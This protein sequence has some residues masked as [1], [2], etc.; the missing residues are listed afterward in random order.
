MAGRTSA[1]DPSAS[2][3][4]R[5]AVLGG[6]TKVAAA[7]A[8]LTAAGMAVAPE[9]AAAG[10][11]GPIGVAPKG[12][13][14]IEFLARIDQD[15]DGLIAYGYLTS[16]AGLDSSALFTGAPGETTARLTAFAS[17]RLTT[18]TIVGEVHNLDVVGEMSIF[19][20]PN[21][22]ASFGNPSSFRSGTKVARY[23]LNLQDV[24][25]VIAPDTGIPT[26][27]GDLR[28]TE[29]AALGPGRPRFGQ[30]GAGLRLQAT[31]LGNRSEP[32]APRAALRVA[33]NLASV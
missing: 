17:G 20:L 8:A 33:G 28:Q 5:R 1:P 14:A 9:F 19:V 13:T 15:G 7:G 22:G 30:V 31:G 11:A 25:T 29:S 10:E 4:S 2:G 6:A 18:R 32:T 3:V 12:T 23:R 26:L 24:L 21:G 27:L 16:V